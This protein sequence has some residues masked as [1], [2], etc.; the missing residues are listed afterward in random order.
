M[1]HLK[2]KSFFTQNH[3]TKFPG[4]NAIFRFFQPIK[5]RHSQCT[6]VQKNHG[7]ILALTKTSN[8]YNSSYLCLKSH[9]N[10]TTDM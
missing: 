3:L 10:L 4:E 7:L 1:S 9:L 6:I 2:E 5:G 8:L